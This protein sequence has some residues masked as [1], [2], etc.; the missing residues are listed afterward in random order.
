MNARP[1]NPR[2]LVLGSANVD[3]I[4]FAEKLPVPGETIGGGIYKMVFGGK[5]ANQA[6]AA[7]RAGADVTMVCSLGLDSLGN[8]CLENL[9]SCGIDTRF[10]RQDPEFATGVALILV[11]KQGENCI[12]VAPGANGN[13]LPSDVSRV[14]EGSDSEYDL[15]I[16]QM[17]INV[18]TVKSAID[19]LSERNIPILLNLAPYQFLPDDVLKKVSILVMNAGEASGQSGLPVSDQKSAGLSAKAIAERT[20]I[21]LIL[22]TLGSAGVLAFQ[23]GES[24]FFP[25]FKVK[26]VDTTGAGDVF[27]GYA[28]TAFAEGMILSESMRLA[29]TASAICVT[30]E[31]AQTSIPFRD[32]VLSFLAEQKG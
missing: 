25:S 7:S 2:I 15:G 19:L 10:I 21:P 12:S 4:V 26:P 27:C 20:G 29:Q 23:N 8:Q 6:V 32:E 24:H 22:I 18:E 14:F 1:K 30:R 11:D 16:L 28:G 17:E 31:G 3:H 5:G 9:K 13:L